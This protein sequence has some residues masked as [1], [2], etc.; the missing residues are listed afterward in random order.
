MEGGIL[1]PRCRSK[2]DKNTLMH[3]PTEFTEN[4]WRG[5]CYLSMYQCTDRT[6]IEV[7]QGGRDVE[8]ASASE[9]AAADGSYDD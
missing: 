9:R 6:A 5:L 8:I 4:N 2:G 3:G 1:W 7:L